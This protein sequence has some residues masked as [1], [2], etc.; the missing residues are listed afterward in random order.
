VISY[1]YVQQ[2]DAPDSVR[3]T[4]T[5]MFVTERWPETTYEYRLCETLFDT[6]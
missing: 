1:D 3:S 6:E 5:A 2:A 4:V